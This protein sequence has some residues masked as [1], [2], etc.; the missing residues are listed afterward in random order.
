MPYYRMLVVEELIETN[1]GE[2]SVEAPT[3]AAAA[4]I[5]IAAHD[6]A[7]GNDTDI[8]R[9]PDGQ[10]GPLFPGDVICNRVFCVLLDDTGA[11]VCEVAPDS[12]TRRAVAES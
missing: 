11:E 5:L 4:S 9:L 12:R 6:A 3:P 8:L 2:F 1:S 7:R 10:T